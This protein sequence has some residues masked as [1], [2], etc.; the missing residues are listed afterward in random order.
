MNRRVCDARRPCGSSRSRLGLPATAIIPLAALLLSACAAVRPFLRAPALP[1]AEL[2][3]AELTDLSF[4][5]AELSATIEVE[6][7]NAFGVTLAGIDYAFAIEDAVPLSGRADKNLAIAPE[8]TSAAVLPVRVSYSELYRSVAALRDKT[9]APYRLELT[10]LIEVPAIGPVELPLQASGSIPLLRLP[11]IAFSGI[12]VSRVGLTGMALA[13]AFE[14]ENPNPG[15]IRFE[16]V[17][18][19]LEIG[20]HHVLSGTLDNRE[21]IGGSETIQQRVITEVRWIDA[22]LAVRDIIVAGGRVPYR[23]DGSLTFAT[24][25][26][27]VGSTTVP[28]EF[29]GDS[30]RPLTPTPANR[31]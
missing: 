21:V 27:F 28:F 23:L 31:D 4:D 24:D 26:P 19:T 9:E 15:T 11:Q 7:P 2:I 20:G 17:P 1:R 25:L 18:Y 8:G 14:I 10:P 22:G 16:A 29:S 5:S 6:N 3:A 30:R 12:E 13:I